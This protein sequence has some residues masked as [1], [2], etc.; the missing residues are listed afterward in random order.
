MMMIA[1]IAQIASLTMKQIN[2]QKGMSKS[3]IVTFC[4]SMGSLIVASFGVVSCMMG[5]H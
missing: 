5:K 2:D 1:G 4:V 3:V